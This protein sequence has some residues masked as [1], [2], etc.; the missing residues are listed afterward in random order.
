[1]LSAVDRYHQ[2]GI[3][4]DEDEIVFAPRI[5]SSPIA[6]RSAINGLANIAPRVRANSKIY[7]GLGKYPA[8]LTYAEVRVL[9]Q[10]SE[11]PH[12]T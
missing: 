4:I 5:S 9:L 3:E 11:W 6:F 12:N 7:R 1:M 8:V 10:R 2:N